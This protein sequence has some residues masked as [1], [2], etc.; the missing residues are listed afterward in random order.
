M[1]V[2]APGLRH[3]RIPRET[4]PY[5]VFSASPSRSTLTHPWASIADDRPTRLAPHPL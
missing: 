1:K 4:T 2:R 3:L 5:A